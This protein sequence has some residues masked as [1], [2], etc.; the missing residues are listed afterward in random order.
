M[1]QYTFIIDTDSYAGNFE[2]EMCAY[3]TGCIGDCEVGE[4][5][6]DKFRKEYGDPEYEFSNV[7]Q[8]ADEHGCYRPCAIQ[9]TPGYINSGYG[10]HFKD[11][12]EGRQQALAHL[13]SEGIKYYTKLRDDSTA[14]LY[15]VTEGTD[16]E[17]GRLGWTKDACIKDIIRQ[18]QRIDEFSALTEARPYPSY[19]SVGI[20][21]QPKPTTA[22]LKLMQERAHQFVKLYKQ[23]KWGSSITIIG[24][25]LLRSTTDEEVPGTW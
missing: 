20:F 22:Q 7:Y 17:L 21:F 11:T 16:E 1:T 8:K 5:W 23:S 3:I 12:S 25:R 19:N 13:K 10:A 2:R 24:F 4:E 15:R 6:A 18:Q 9:T 14:R